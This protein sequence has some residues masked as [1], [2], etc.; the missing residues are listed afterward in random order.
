MYHDISPKFLFTMTFVQNEKKKIFDRTT[1]I[2]SSK[3]KNPRESCCF[4]VYSYVF[5]RNL[6]LLSFFP[7]RLFIFS[8]SKLIKN[9]L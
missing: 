5:L 8:I 2:K 6:N 3:Q 1:E 4:L 7:I 9:E